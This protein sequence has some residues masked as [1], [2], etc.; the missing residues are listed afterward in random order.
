[1]ATQAAENFVQT[2][3]VAYYGRPADSDGLAYWA[4]RVDEEGN[5]SIVDAFGSSMEFTTRFGSLSPED[6]VDNLYQQLFGRDAESTGL[7]YWVDQFQSGQRSLA[8]ISV[9]IAEGAQGDDMVARD[10]KVTAAGAF[11]EALDTQAEMAAYQGSDALMVGRDYLDPVTDPASAAAADPES[12]VA[13][14]DPVDGKLASLNAGADTLG[15]TANRDLFMAPLA[16]NG[17][18]TLTSEDTL[19]GLGGDDTL[20]ATL[21]GPVTAAPDLNGIE[22]VQVGFAGEP[23]A[24]L[25]LSNTE[26]VASVGVTGSSSPG[27]VTDLGEVSTFKVA[28]QSTTVGFSSVTAP[29]FTLAL[30]NVAAQAD[31]DL[32][33]ADFDD[34]ETTDIKVE[35]TNSTAAL[36]LANIVRDEQGNQV[37]DNSTLET[38]TVEATGNNT[39]GVTGTG[40]TTTLNVMGEGNVTLVAGDVDGATSVNPVD[41]LNLQTE[42]NPGAF[43]AL[44]MVNAGD[45]GG[46]IILTAGAALTSADLGSGDDSLTIADSDDVASAGATVNAGDGNDTLR[47]G[48]GEDTLNGQAGEDLLVGGQGDDT[49]NGGDGDDIFGGLAG[50]DILTGGFGNDEFHFDAGVGTDTITDFDNNDDVISFLDT[51]EGAIQF[52]NS[53][54]DAVR[55]DSDLAAGDF[56]IRT[57]LANTTSGDDQKVVLLDE[58]ADADQLMMGTGAA[59]EFYLVANNSD[60]GNAEIYYDQD[61]SD[62]A[63]REQIAILNGVNSNNL[64][65]ENFDVY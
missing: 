42:F 28:N 64:S 24:T 31:G 41:G 56:Q 54:T 9:A 6:M 37:A 48:R 16:D 32:A 49:L 21:S 65:I 26:G 60:S 20:R 34:I 10:A 39:L 38:L 58:A 36:G 15:G 40:N 52:A 13:A 3:Y 59:A 11:T 47:G 62:S 57:S 30:S 46:N 45:A 35:A 23:G 61:W 7:Q 14:L 51:D 33:V 43:E 44:E 8:D 12:T 25:D 29:S 50:D 22:N 55:G 5:A 63:G 18:N 17:G 53:T 4:D 2:M 19:N 1:M 27:F